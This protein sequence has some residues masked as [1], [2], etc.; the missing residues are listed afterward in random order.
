MWADSESKID[1]LNYS[2]VSEMV[3]DMVTD[4]AMLPISLGIYGTWGV[5]KSSILQLIAEQLDGDKRNLIVPFDAWLY[6][7]FEEA[8]AALMTVIAKTVYESVPESFKERAASLYR[9]VNKLKVLGIAADVGAF[10]AG[11]PTLGAFTKAADAASD[12][13]E[14]ESDEDDVE[15]VKGAVTEVGKRT[16]GLLKPKEKR[17]A[18]EEIVA[19]R[20]E[21]G[22][23][24]E[25]VD[26]RL[27]VFVDNLDRCLPPN[28]ISTLE[29]MRLFLFL[30]NTAFIVAADEDM[31]RLAVA[32]HFK[33]PGDRHIT[34]YL[35]KLI[36]VPLRV[37]KLGLQE[38]R[39]YLFMLAAA[40]SSVQAE[41]IEALRK[42]LIDKLRRSWSD[43]AP[44]S[45]EE[46]LAR[47]GLPR[48]AEL[49]GSLETMDRLAGILAHSI[50]V[51]GN[52]RIVK[53]MLNVIRM[54]VSVAKRRG[55]ALDESVIAKLA[56]FER[57]TSEDAIKTLNAMI[58][59]APNGKSTE[60]AQFEALKDDLKP[61][62]MPKE[63][64]K[65][66]DFISD[67]LML[68]PPLGDV[69]LRPAVYLAR[70]TMP[71]RVNTRR[72]SE[73]AQNA[74]EIL[75]KTATLSSKA[76]REA[77]EGLDASEAGEV[78]DEI[79]AVMKRNPDWDKVRDDFRGA[80]LL[81]KVHEAAHRKLV[82]FV[83]TLPR[84]PRWMAALMKDDGAGVRS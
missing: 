64:Q 79:V 29:A 76:S 4:D 67:W 52:P 30:P 9:R 38:V 71:V 20:K 49:E 17:N 33:D 69:D 62:A 43:E 66:A 57:C 40:K 48:G 7:D 6:Q 41:R 44:F 8:K 24:L 35:D 45:V 80:R 60:L 37:P 61:E 14:G 63:W 58:H 56:L 21:F 81:A 18:P 51:N 77:V 11:V 26:R 65:H 73:R 10:L 68:H 2:E 42:F 54:R 15:A 83:Q 74:V 75:L 70:E 22:E 72:M 3:C 84:T 53:R 19:F 28:A 78:M 13:F 1:Y 25:S 5:G 47:L 27:I 16:S 23:L 31:I 59:S 39:A 36:Q 55:M 32:K 34:D 50:Q 82:A 46:A 12:A